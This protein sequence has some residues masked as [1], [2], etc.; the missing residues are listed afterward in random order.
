[1]ASPTTDVRPAP[2]N[3]VTRRASPQSWVAGP[4]RQ[5]LLALVAYCGISV[6]LFGRGVVGSPHEHVVGDRGSDKT[7]FVWAFEW[8]PYALAR[9]EDPLSAEVVWAPD[10]MDLSWVAASPGA[11][12]LFSPFTYVFGPVVAYNLAALLAPAAACTTAF[13]LGR[14][15]T[16]SFWPAFV[17]GLLFG[18]SSYEVGQTIGH[19]HLTLVFPIPLCLLLVLRRF[20]H[21]LTRARFVGYLTATL[22]LQFLFSTEVFLL[23]VG[24]GLLSLVLAWWVLGPTARA[25]LRTVATE[26]VGALIATAVVVSPYLVHA[27]VLTGPSWAPTRSPL[28]AAADVANFVVPRNW[29]W[30]Q[31]PGSEEIARRFTANPVESTA[32][33]GLPL[34][35]VVVHFALK[36]GRPRPQV[37]LLVVLAATAF[38]SLGAWVRIAGTTVA[39]GPWQ[40]FA[41]LPLTKSALPVRLTLFVALFAALVCAIWLVER[42]SRLR[43]SIAAVAIVVL[44]PTPSTAF[45]T[46][47]VPRSTFFSGGAVARRFDPDDVLLVLPY[48]RAGW[49]MAWQAESGFA[50]RM[51]GGRLGNLPPDEQRWQPLLHVLAGRPVTPEARRLLPA[52]LAEHGVDAVV[53]APGTRPGPRQLVETLDVEPVRVDDARVYLLER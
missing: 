27:L 36:R 20:G 42:R 32:Y 31:P 3:T 24:V 11:A 39:V 14:W 21:E 46:A 18:F 38:V 25:D 23:L 30:L 22:S 12:L 35:A 50:Y 37:L 17:C 34:V 16:G 48:G 10:G 6:L 19:L 44:L 45:W 26:S 8:F 1:M 53:V 51:A 40:V 41:R 43:W 29:T 28:D 33:L 9:L 15:V 47:D 2:G 4:R 49:S 52:F 5:S 7:I 13:L